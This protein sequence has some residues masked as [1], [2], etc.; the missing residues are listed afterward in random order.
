ALL[1]KAAPLAASLRPRA[2]AVRRA[3]TSSS[4][5]SRLRPSD[6]ELGFRLTRAT[7]TTTTASSSCFGPASLAA[8]LPLLLWGPIY[9]SLEQIRAA[10]EASAPGRRDE[11]SKGAANW[12]KEVGIGID[13]LRRRP[14]QAPPDRDERH[15]TKLL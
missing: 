3:L 15:R 13:D 7:T 8:R 4:A 6:D 12:E 1:S 2:S 5:P 14:I 10:F 11:V 9:G